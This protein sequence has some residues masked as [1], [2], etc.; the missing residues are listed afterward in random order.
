MIHKIILVEGLP[1]SGKTTFTKRLKEYYTELGIKVKSYNEGDLHP[2]DLAWCSILD[3]S[4]YFKLLEKHNKYK[5]QI[6]KQSKKVKGK[7]IVAYTKLRV[8]DQDVSIYDDYSKYEI[9]KENDLDLFLQAHLELWDKFESEDTL[10]IF[11][12]IFLQNHINELI[13]KHNKDQSFM[14]EYF[15]KLVA[16]ISKSNPILFYV[17]QNNIDQTL[18]RIIEER[19]SD[20]PN[21]KDWIELVDDYLKTTR[22]AAELN[23]TGSDGVVRYF[24]DRR[25]IELDIIPSLEMVSLIF[26]LDEDYDKVFEEMKKVQI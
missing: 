18:N 12:C 14:V 20:N 10:Y 26:E 24:K 4:T 3:S 11:E 1:G 19:K 7:Y 9:Y 8:D 13:L 2:I 21:Y 15:N 16:S 23:Y 6:I 22:Y 17:K 25:D 5:D